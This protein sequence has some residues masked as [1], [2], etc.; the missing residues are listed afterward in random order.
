VGKFQCKAW[1]DK[2]PDLPLSKQESGATFMT[3]VETVAITEQQKFKSSP[4]E[5]GGKI[6]VLIV[7]DG[8]INRKLAK[9]LI[10]QLGGKADLAENGSEAVEACEKYKSIS[11]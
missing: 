9:I 11:S 5:D 2:G 1:Q 6:R 4:G 7:D 10:E 3:A 8:D